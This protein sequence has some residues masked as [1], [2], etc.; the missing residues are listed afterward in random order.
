MKQFTVVFPLARVEG[1]DYILLG[2]Q[3]PGKPLA[4]YL[5]GY[6]GKVEE[7]DDGPAGSLPGSKILRAAERELQEELGIPLENP[8]YIGS[9]IHQTK[10][11]FFYLATIKYAPYADTAEMINNT[12]F[13]LGGNEF[14]D[15]M[16]PGDSV[17]IDHIIENIDNYFEN[18]EI[19]EFKIVKEG[20]EIDRAVQEL[21]KS[22]GFK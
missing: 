12:W 13:Q 7:I 22:I 5:N 9:I 2:E 10:E 17:I 16:L 21:N 11:I 19:S 8:T 6:G 15:K 4:G 14:I 1:I 20:V 3:K 18:R